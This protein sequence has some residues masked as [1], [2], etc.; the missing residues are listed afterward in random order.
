MH[1]NFCIKAIFFYYHVKQTF[2]VSFYCTF[3]NLEEI[4]TGF[5]M[6]RFCSLAHLSNA[7]TLFLQPLSCPSFSTSPAEACQLILFPSLFPYLLSKHFPFLLLPWLKYHSNLEVT[8][9]LLFLEK[10]YLVLISPLPITGWL[11]IRHFNQLIVHVQK[12]FNILK[13]LFYFCC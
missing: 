5:W 7:L 6:F 11:Y 9:S 2:E 3:E 1:G 13:T 4:K 10:L 8:I 12:C